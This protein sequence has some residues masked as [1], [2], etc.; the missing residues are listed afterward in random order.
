M[1]HCVVCCLVHSYCHDGLCLSHGLTHMLYV[2][3]CGVLFSL[4][5][6]PWCI[7]VSHGLKHILYVTLCGVL[8]S[9]WSLPWCI[10]VSHGLTHILHVTLCVVSHMQC[11]VHGH[12]H[13]ALYMS[14]GLTH[15][16]DYISECA[17]HVM[18]HALNLS[19]IMT[20]TVIHNVLYRCQ[21]AQCTSCQIS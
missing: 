4:W 8:L 16:A 6:M 18:Y 2:T 14:H 3:L 5:S 10:V 13:D 15:S 7:V 19:Y 20:H 1:S 11:S 17:V 12:C 21:N 9:A